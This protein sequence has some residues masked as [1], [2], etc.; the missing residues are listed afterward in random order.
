MIQE[1]FYDLNVLL[2][3]IT[4]FDQILI[5]ILDQLHLFV[6]SCSHNLLEV[7]ISKI[8]M[9]SENVLHVLLRQVYEIDC[10][11][12]FILEHSLMVVLK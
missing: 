9:V 11:I 3:M 12:V 6:A 8:K 10:I 1:V 5:V 2:H 7:Y 4:H